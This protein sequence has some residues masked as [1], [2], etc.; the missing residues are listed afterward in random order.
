VGG[1]RR[2]QFAPDRAVIHVHQINLQPAVG[3]GEVYT[4]WFTRALEQAG[5]PVTL[6]VDQANTFW[7]GLASDRIKVVGVRNGNDIARRL[8]DKGALIVTQ[9]GIPGELLRVAARDHVLTGFAHMPMVDRSASGFARY[10]AV[11]TVS[12]YCIGLL[13][14]AGI[15]QV[16]PEP[17]YGTFQLDRA[18]GTGAPIRA[19]SPYHWDRRKGRDRLFSMLEPL[20]RTFRTQPV[21]VRKPGLTLGIV[22]LLSPIKQFP[23]LFAVLAPV[24]ARFPQVNLEI[25]GN[26]GYAQVRDLR[27]SLSLIAHKVR[28]WGYQSDVQSIYPNLDYLMTGLPEKEALGLNALEAQALGTPVLAPDAPP[29]TE[30]VLHG[31]SGFLYRDPRLDGGSDFAGLLGSLVDGRPRPDPRDATNH[32][33]KFSFDAMVGRT[34]AMLAFLE[35]QFPQARG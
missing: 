13:R 1:S 5:A 23:A 28:F 19:G 20:V 6:Y 21:Y 14:K 8:P 30:T 2:L 17:M 34:R 10:A 33:A 15:Q 22:S 25:F 27:R 26:G 12:E 31:R 9:S 4:R 32:L 35:H 18:A 29:F 24:I 3:G 16:Y 7:G 11:F